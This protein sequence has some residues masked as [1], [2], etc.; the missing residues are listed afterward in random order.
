MKTNKRH[1]IEITQL[2][3]TKPALYIKLSKSYT[4]KVGSYNHFP[5]TPGNKCNF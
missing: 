3:T 4:K 5:S 1:S 2:H